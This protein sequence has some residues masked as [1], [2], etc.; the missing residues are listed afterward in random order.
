M[1]PK[2]ILLV[3]MI[4][5]TLFLNWKSSAR[6]PAVEPE[7]G[8]N[9]DKYPVVAPEDN[10]G[11][12]FTAGRPIDLLN[13]EGH[14]PQKQMRFVLQQEWKTITTGIVSIFF[15]VTFSWRRYLKGQRQLL[16]PL[17]AANMV[18]LKTQQQKQEMPAS[19]QHSQAS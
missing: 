5:S 12:D 7:M 9:I 1:K 8:L 10:I 16:E 3:A 13:S 4:V 17:T 11:Y 14:S 2:I 18:E 19:E 6:Q 15:L